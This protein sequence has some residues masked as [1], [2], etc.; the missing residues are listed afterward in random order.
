MKISV[1]KFVFPARFFGIRAASFPTFD[2][3]SAFVLPDLSAA[4]TAGISR[5]TSSDTGNLKSARLLFV[6]MWNWKF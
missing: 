6:M 5:T 3:I 4:A 1:T 2:N